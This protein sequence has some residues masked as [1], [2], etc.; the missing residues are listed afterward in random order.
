MPLVIMIL[1]WLDEFAL[2]SSTSSSISAAMTHGIEGLS[3]DVVEV[4][5]GVD[6]LVDLTHHSDVIATHNVKPKDNLFDAWGRGE[7]SLVSVVQNDVDS[8]VETLQSSNEVPSICSDDWHEPV[9]IALEGRHH[10]QIVFICNNIQWS[11]KSA[12][13]VQII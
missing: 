8:L 2:D 11:F 12:Q 9:N 4:E 3:L 13:Q 7:N 6:V 5:P 1:I 10:N